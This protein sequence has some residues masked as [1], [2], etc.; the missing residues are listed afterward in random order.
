MNKKQKECNIVLS[1]ITHFQLAHRIRKLSLPK[2]GLLK[3]EQ[4]EMKMEQT[5]MKNILLHNPPSRK[6][7]L[8]FLH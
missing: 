5:E 1:A 8:I 6:T 4:T 2:Y 7:T 3:M